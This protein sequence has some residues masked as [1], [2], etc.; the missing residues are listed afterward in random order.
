MLQVWPIF[1]KH[2]LPLLLLDFTPSYFTQVDKRKIMISQNFGYS[3]YLLLTWFQNCI[4]W[5]SLVAQ[6]LKDL[7]LSLLWHGFNPWPGNFHMPWAGPKL[8]ILVTYHILPQGIILTV[9]S[10]SFQKMA[11]RGCCRA[12]C[13]IPWTSLCSHNEQLP[14]IRHR[15][16]SFSPSPHLFIYL[17]IYLFLSF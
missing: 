1:K 16:Q 5:S 13:I 17:F 9:Y 11:S 2:N 6:L 4:S 10:L 8:C 15:K 3:N 12:M 14:A 7:A